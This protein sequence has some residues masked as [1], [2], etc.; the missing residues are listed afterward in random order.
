MRYKSA[1]LTLMNDSEMPLSDD[2]ATIYS[3]PEDADN[4]TFKYNQMSLSKTKLCILYMFVLLE[5][6][7]HFCQFPFCYQTVLR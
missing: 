7:V 4:I 6:L 3:C 5:F 1:A 2:H